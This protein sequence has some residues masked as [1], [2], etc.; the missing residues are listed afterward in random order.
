MVE[1]A[2]GSSD[3]YTSLV[4]RNDQGRLRTIRLSYHHGARESGWDRTKNQ[5]P[6]PERSDGFL[7]EPLASAQEAYESLICHTTSPRTVVERIGPESQDRGI[8]CEQCHGPGRHHLAAVAFKFADPVIASPAPASHAEI[9]RLCGVCHSQ[10]FTITETLGTRESPEWARFPSSTL[11]WS[12]CYTESGGALSCATCHDPHRNAATSARYYEAKC[13][14]CHTTATA[15]EPPRGRT[16]PPADSA[17]R[18]PCRVNPRED[19]L[20]CHMPKVHSNWLHGSITDNYI[21]SHAEAGAA[22]TMPPPEA[23]A[24]L[25]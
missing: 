8:G 22:G 12:R 1:Y 7:G 25:R 2:L 20:R 3:R 16:A 9:N 4:G 15:S 23:A 13:L 6:R 14:S 24:R 19:C 18:S 11:T 17:F 21:R 10:D 5:K